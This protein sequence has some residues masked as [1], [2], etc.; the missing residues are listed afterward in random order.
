MINSK[1]IDQLDVAPALQITDE[2]PIVPTGT[3]IAKKT[4]LG[5]LRGLV[6]PPL[7]SYANDAAADADTSLLSGGFYLITGGRTVFQK[8]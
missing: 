6:S 8:P 4:T 2:I 5:L 1:R 7:T 3:I